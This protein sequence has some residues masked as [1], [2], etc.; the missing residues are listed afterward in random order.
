MAK[1]KYTPR[2]DEGIDIL[3]ILLLLLKYKK[4]IVIATAGVALAVLAFAGITA[5]LPPEMS[6]YPDVYRAEAV[7]SINQRIY[8]DV[9]SSIFTPSAGMSMSSGFSFSSYSFS[10]GEY[11]MKIMRSKTIL[12]AL[13]QE[14]GIGKRYNME[15]T[16]L[17][18]IRDEIMKHLKLDFDEK[19]LTVNITYEDYNPD[20]A[21]RMVNKLVSLLDT[22][23]LEIKGLQSSKQKE[24]LAKKLVD[25]Q[26]QLS[27][28]EKLIKQLQTQYGVIQIETLTEEKITVLANL[29]SQF[30]LKE[31]EIRTYQGS[32]ALEDPY[33]LK[34]K[35]ERDNLQKLIAEIETGTARGSAILPSQKLLPDIVLQFAHLRRDLSIQEKIYEN[36]LQE[37]EITKI[38]IS[39][40]GEE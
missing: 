36:L 22:R 27:E 12:D 16:R 19:T 37:F 21:Q 17:G 6:M 29:R 38:K 33:I 28:Y 9:L 3:S 20:F 15:D 35:N 30:I 11:L 14:F 39:I 34:L 26:S 32:L 24:L 2:H 7:I 4:F 13:T 25:V 23:M 18:K 31:M 1:E 8:S 10:Y 40:E 5:V